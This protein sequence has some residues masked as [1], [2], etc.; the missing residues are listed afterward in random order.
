M[1]RWLLVFLS[2]TLAACSSVS[3][4]FSNKQV[5]G[6]VEYISIEETG[7]TYLAR[8]DT[9]ATKVSLHAWDM[10]VQDPAPIM[11]DNVGK[12]IHFKTSNESGKVI[13]ADAEIVDIVMVRSSHGAKMRYVVEMNLAFQGQSKPVEV[14]LNNRDSM[15][16]PLLLGR[17]WLSGD[18]LVDVERP[19][20][21]PEQ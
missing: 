16:Y 5:V 20:I 9:G 18:F 10:A 7:L 21:K 19:E 2:L 14:N 4:P 12:T 11:E 13:E 8:V 6:P 17:N 3:G 1:Q 15:T